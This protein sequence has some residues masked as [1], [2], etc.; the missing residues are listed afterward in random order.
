MSAAMAIEAVHHDVADGAGRKATLAPL[1]RRFE[2]GSFTVVGGPS[3]V[4]K[5]T[6]LSLMSLAV[7]AAGGF[8]RHGTDSLTGM[9]PAQARAWR[10]SSPPRDAAFHANLIKPF[11]K[12]QVGQCLPHPF[13]DIWRRLVSG[14]CRLCPPG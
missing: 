14:K 4:G 7:P 1:S 12:L 5:T 13:L 8:I 2:P 11:D 3:G 9:S 10:R 6:L